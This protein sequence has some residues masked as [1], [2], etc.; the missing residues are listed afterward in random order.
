MT[1][2][3]LYLLAGVL[4]LDKTAY[5]DTLLDCGL[6]SEAQIV[7]I[8][9]ITELVVA[10]QAPASKNL[11]N[12]VWT[13][14]NRAIAK[15]LSLGRDVFFKAPNL[16]IRKRRGVFEQHKRNAHVT[17]LFFLHTLEQV[18]M[19]KEFDKARALE[20]Y[21][22][23]SCAQPGLDCH[24]YQVE[25][26]WSFTYLTFSEH[27]KLLPERYGDDHNSPHHLETI[28][29]HIQMVKDALK[30]LDLSKSD[31]ELLTKVADYHDLGKYTT[32]TPN[33]KHP[34]YDIYA[35]HENVSSIYALAL[36]E[37]AQVQQLV[38]YHMLAHSFNH[39]AATD[40]ASVAAQT[41]E[42]ASS[43][44]LIDRYQLSSE[45]VRLL[46]LFSKADSLGRRT[47]V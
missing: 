12:A 25:S 39:V 1:Q 41:S 27:I 30:T 34:E 29:E 11:T 43:E 18:L 37:S 44:G 42:R 19:A 6:I 15:Q 5:L 16:S 36:G 32:R 21:K 38:R 14:V 2:P 8:D 13:M 9:H 20:S 17:T 45:T 46:T 31:F 40:P 28:S 47:D 33:P 23:L 3:T 26:N 22:Q 4:N 7:D 35:G 24:D 10:H